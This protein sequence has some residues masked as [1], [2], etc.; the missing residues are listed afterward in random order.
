MPVGNVTETVRDGGLGTVPANTSNLHVVLG[1]S[2]L[3]TV[4]TLYSF[5]SIDDITATV[6]TGPGPEAAAY[7]LAIA[8][9]SVYFMPI[10]A[11]VAGVASAVTTT[12]VASSTS[13][14]TTIGTPSDA[15]SAIVK[16]TT[17]GT[18]QIVS[19]GAIGILISL[20]G[21]NTWSQQI[22][23]P[24]S[25]NYTIAGTGLSLSFTT[26]SNATLDFG[27]QFTF[28]CQPP[29]YSSADLNNAFT[30]LGNDPR[31]WGF[32][33]VV[34]Y[35]TA[36]TSSA[37]A[38]AS[39]SLASSI[40]T[41]M[42]TFANNFRWARCIMEAPPSA[43]A[44]LISAFAGFADGRVK[45]EATTATITSPITGRKMLRSWAWA[46]S[47]R[48]AAVSVSTSPGRIADGPM[49]G[50]TAITRDERKTPGLFDQRFGV[51]QTIIGLNGFYSDIGRTM[52]PVGSDFST[53]MNG[54]VMDV[55][56][57]V[58]RGALLSFLNSTIRVNAAT[59]TILEQDARGI[60]K[61]VESQLRAALVSTGDASDCSVQV[62]RTDNIL[63]TQLL[64]V[65]TR[66]VPN[67]YAAAISEDIGFLNPTLVL[68]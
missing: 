66:V 7:E 12:R 16:V 43:D 51:S 49:R 14:M 6:G 2:S 50:V 34:G 8:G 59:G 10:N 33:H 24:S 54:R 46:V 56:C 22:T 29:F 36:G 26:A 63:S 31:T 53:I 13:V 15:Y 67:G 1:T 68:S 9:G 52:A 32:L 47:A 65:K 17:S 23:L 11:S 5:S 4:N 61:F 48:L 3:G 19:N 39:A 20:D 64:R 41:S 28:A 40:S 37:N 18:G 57:T 27:D 38:I 58:T 45:I 35:P 60:E 42:A 21:G 55:A 44:D 62:N 30:A 25:G